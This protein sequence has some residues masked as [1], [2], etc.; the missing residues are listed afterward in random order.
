MDN[1]LTK[2]TKEFDKIFTMLKEQRFV[3]AGEALIHKNHEGRNY[4]GSRIR[5]T[6]G[7]SFDNRRPQPFPI[8]QY[9]VEE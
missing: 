9:A 6:I 8:H 2:F 1:G 7:R 3:I 5:P 4:G